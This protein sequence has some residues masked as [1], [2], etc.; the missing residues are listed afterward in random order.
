MKNI[1]ICLLMIFS[2]LQ[3]VSAKPKKTGKQ[4]FDRQEY[5]LAIPVYQQELKKKKTTKMTQAQIETQIGICYYYLNKPKDAV[6]W[7]KKGIAKQYETAEVYGIYGLSLQKQEKY[8]EALEAF[9]VCQKKDKKYPNIQRHIQTCEYAITHADPNVS[10]QMRSAKI[11]TDG[12]EYGISPAGSDIFFSRASTKGKDIDPRTGLGFTE[13][14]S[15]RLEYNELIN[16]RKEKAF[17]KTYYNTGLFAFDPATNYMYVTMCDPKSGRCGIYTSRFDRK[18][19]EKPEPLFTNA[20][21]DMAHPA[22]AK[23]GQRL[24]F[25]SNAPGGKGKTDIWY[26]DRTSEDS[27]SEAKNAG[28]R[29]NTAGR[30]EFPF[31]ENDS[32]LYFASDGLMGYGGLD[33]FAASLEEGEI[34][35]VINIERPFNSGADDFNLVTFGENGLLVSSRNVTRSDDIYIFS[36]SALPSPQRRSKP[37]AEPVEEVPEVKAPEEEPAPPKD[38]VIATIYFDFDKFIP[39]HQ[40]R[41]E[42]EKIVALMKS[43]PNAVFEVAGYADTRGGTSFNR[44]LS[45]K[46]AEYI[47]KRLI[48]RGMSKNQIVPKGY[49]F[50]KPVVPNATSESEFQKNRRVEIR[51]MQ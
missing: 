37:K 14:Y 46:R 28:E 31:V 34:G 18:K 17:M 24:Y 42:Y 26:V 44:S 12:S 5:A 23:N 41:R 32:I 39:Q 6:T 16:P 20:K 1:G 19:W 13:I 22:L 33:I 25:T 3:G 10:V 47:A 8:E 11:N 2:L 43:Y 27:W 30:E 15:T 35:D 9:R 48:D 4:H 7:L 36:K 49:G 21:Y 50:D 45:I 51:I 40:Y 38:A 29:I